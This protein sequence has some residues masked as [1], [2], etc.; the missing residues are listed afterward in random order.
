MSDTG[1]HSVSIKPNSL[2]LLTAPHLLI[3]HF[4]FTVHNHA[5]TYMSGDRYSVPSRS[6]LN[7]MM[8]VM[9]TVIHFSVIKLGI[10]RVSSKQPIKYTAVWSLTS[11]HN[12]SVPLYLRCYIREGFCWKPLSAGSFKSHKYFWVFSTVWTCSGDHVDSTWNCGESPGRCF[13]C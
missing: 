2:R 13:P 11:Q 1:F 3:F 12:A 10:P 8:K 6:T 9:I 4:W 7:Y 5:E